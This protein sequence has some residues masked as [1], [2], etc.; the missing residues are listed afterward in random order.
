MIMFYKKQEKGD[1]IIPVKRD[2]LAC[3]LLKKSNSERKAFYIRHSHSHALQCNESV[4][5]M[6]FFQR[7]ILRGILQKKTCKKQLRLD[8]NCRSCGKACLVVTERYAH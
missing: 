2:K 3:R 8:S 6:L 7:G 5:L 4:C 1:S